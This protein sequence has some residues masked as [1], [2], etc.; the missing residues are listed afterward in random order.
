MRSRQESPGRRGYRLMLGCLYFFI[1]IGV[2]FVICELCFPKLSVYGNKT[3]NGTTAEIPSLFVCLPAW[4]IFGTIPMAWLTYLIGYLFQSKRH[5]LF[6]ANAVVMPLGIIILLVFLIRRR[7]KNRKTFQNLVENIGFGELLFVLIVTVLY[8]VLFF[9]TFYCRDNKYYIGWTVQ[10]DFSP[11]IG[12]IRSF[13][14]GNNFPTQYSHFAGADIKY[15]FMF[16]FFVGNLNYLGLRLDW[17]FNFPSIW[18]MVCTY[19]LLYFYAVKLTGRKAVGYLTTFLFSFRSSYAFLDFAASIPKGQTIAQV[20][21]AEPAFIGT[22]EHEDWGLWNLNVYCNQRH[23]AI[24]L[25]VLLFLLIYFTQ[26]LYGQAKRVKEQ[27]DQ[28]LLQFLTDNPDE[29]LLPGEKF[30]YM[31]RESL[32]RKEGWI[33]RNWTKAAAC[34]ILLGMCSFFNGAC[35]IACLCVLFVMA[36]VSDRRLEFALTAAIAVIISTLTTRFFIDGNALNPVFY[37]GFLAKNRTFFGVIKYIITLC[38]LLPFVILAAQFFLDR[39]GKFLTFA[40][41]APVILAFTCSMTI[42]V[43]VNHKYIMMGIMLLC[44]PAAVLLTKIWQQRG[45]YAKG[46]AILLAVALTITGIYEFQV[47]LGRNEVRR[48]HVWVIDEDS[49]ICRWVKANATS[50]DIFLTSWYS[51]NDYVLGGAMLYFGWPYYAWSAGYDTYGREKTVYKMYEAQTP[52]ELDALVKEY[53]IRYIVVDEEVRERE[54]FV[55]NEQ[56]IINTYLLVFNDGKTRIFDASKRLGVTG[57]EQ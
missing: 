42:D 15:H 18:F 5:P 19:M 21:N 32:F 46:I 57:G 54:E 7:V 39:V 1:C 51:L 37:F 41:T 43:A 2:G 31:V 4:S 34:G 23:L 55:V 33:S 35:V 49:D 22:T 52:D 36:W 50:K 16:Q 53:G 47:I 20:Y 10:S 28:K 24:G 11:H 27:A 14:L 26:F 17:A 3:Y 25:C 9:W 30:E 13:A 44:I 8:M 48:N 45:M 6:Y 40:F 12:M 38:G 29:E 56:N